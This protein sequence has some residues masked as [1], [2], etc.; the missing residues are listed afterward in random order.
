[1]RGNKKPRTPPL[2]DADRIIY[3]QLVSPGKKVDY[4]LY[5]I[6]LRLMALEINLKNNA[7]NLGI[8]A[9]L[10]RF[11]GEGLEETGYMHTFGHIYY[12]FKQMRLNYTKLDIVEELKKAIAGFKRYDNRVTP[13]DL[14]GGRSD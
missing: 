7:W 9:S 1:M 11:L 13:N 4:Q 3:K 10:V 5:K 14:E 6:E 8:I 12:K 2:L